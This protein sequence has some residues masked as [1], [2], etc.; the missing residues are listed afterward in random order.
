MS[1]GSESMTPT[2]RGSPVT[3]ASTPHKPAAASKLVAASATAA[4]A[5]AAAKWRTFST[6][7]SRRRSFCECVCVCVCVCVRYDVR[8]YERPLR[9]SSPLTSHLLIAPLCSSSAGVRS[10]CFFHLCSLSSSFL[11]TNKIWWRSS[12]W[13]CHFFFLSVCVCPFVFWRKEGSLTRNVQDS[14][15]YIL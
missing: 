11:F 4:A 1:S 8:E 3:A 13:S 15:G 10:S 9:P 2:G 14:V 7:P 6:D 12:W 5:A